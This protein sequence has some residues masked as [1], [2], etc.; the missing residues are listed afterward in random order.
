MKE[1]VYTS[2]VV[3][4]LISSI[5]WIPLLMYFM[6]SSVPSPREKWITTQGIVLDNGTTPIFNATVVIYTDET[7]ME[8]GFTN[9]SGRFEV[10]SP[11]PSN[12]TL[13]VSCWVYAQGYYT[14][15]QTATV[16]TNMTLVKSDSGAE[17]WGYV[18][19][20]VKMVSMLTYGGG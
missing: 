16:P 12:L 5:I 10:Y 18:N 20:R 1:K 2:I 13:S 19:F 15:Y 7:Y 3:V 17:Y 11:F 4:V 8:K 14:V 6:R 9:K